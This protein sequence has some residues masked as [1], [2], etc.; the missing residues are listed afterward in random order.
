[1]LTQNSTTRKSSADN[2]Q[3]FF[4]LACFFIISNETSIGN[5]KKWLD[6]NCITWTNKCQRFFDTT[7]KFKIVS[8]LTL[9][10]IR[11]GTTQLAKSK[12]LIG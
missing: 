12:L 11:D 5:F 10:A 8:L 3:K 4:N 9:V 1:M 6:I 7:Q 2:P